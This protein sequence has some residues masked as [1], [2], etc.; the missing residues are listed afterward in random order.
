MSSTCPEC[1]M[2]FSRRE[3]MLRHKR[4][5]HGTT[6]RIQ[7]SDAYPPPPP[8]RGCV[9]AVSLRFVSYEL[10]PVVIVYVMTLHPWK[11]TL[12]G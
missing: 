3:A 2:E 9:K 10:L 11:R 7:S 8:P 6:H 4:N 5:K 12:H 1:E